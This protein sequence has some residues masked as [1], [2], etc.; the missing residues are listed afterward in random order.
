MVVVRRL[1]SKKHANKTPRA[2]LQ[3]GTDLAVCVSK[4]TKRREER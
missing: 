3:F 4:K 1:R 2:K